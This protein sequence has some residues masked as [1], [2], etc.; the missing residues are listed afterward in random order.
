MKVLVIGGGGREHAILWA[1]KHTATI[2]VTLYCS[3]GN[4]GI[5]SIAQCVP[6]ADT[7]A[8]IDFARQTGIDLTVVGPEAPLAAGIVDGFQNAALR[9]VGPTASAARLESS[10]VFAKDFMRRHKIPTA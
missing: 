2:P 4:G 6:L 5:A 7:A 8:I 1:L 10:K 9:I 3:P